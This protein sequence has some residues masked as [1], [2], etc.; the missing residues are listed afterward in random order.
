M[1]VRLSN[2]MAAALT[3][4]SS[5]S[6]TTSK[7][8]TNCSTIGSNQTIVVGPIPSLLRG[9]G[10]SSESKDESKSFKTQKLS[11]A[12]TSISSLNLSQTNGVKSNPQKQT[13]S[14][15]KGMNTKSETSPYDCVDID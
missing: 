6:L 15:E 4:P 3:I 14:S 12:Q 9:R 13:K 7:T 10:N 1:P 5:T 2:G 11:S 8:S